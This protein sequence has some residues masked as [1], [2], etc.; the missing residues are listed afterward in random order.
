MKILIAEKLSENKFKTSEGYLI[1]KDAILARTG[2]QT[3]KRSELFVDST[4]ETLVDVDRE[5]DEVFADATIASFENKPLTVEHPDE[6]VDINNHNELSVGF[7]RDVQQSKF[8]GHDVMTATLV[9]TD[10]DAV[11][12]IENGR[13]GFL[14]CGY[15]CDITDIDAPKMVNI[16]GNHVALCDNPRAGITKILD[17]KNELSK[18]NVTWFNMKDSTSHVDII[19]AKNDIDVCD[20][21]SRRNND[22]WPDEM[23]VSHVVKDD[24]VVYDSCDTFDSFLKA[25]SKISQSR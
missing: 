18:Y 22:V 16:R 13:Y 10:A 11:S 7:V 8:E 20:E 25:P 12:D 9:V 24:V 6:D 19:R 14:S 5:F 17:S 1:C 23:L 2:S 21:L 15:N 3:Y 4:D